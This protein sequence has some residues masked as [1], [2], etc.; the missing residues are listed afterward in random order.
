MR[1]SEEVKA[2]L[3]EP[4][5]TTK[6]LGKGTGL[7]LATCYGIVCQSGGDIRVYS[8]PNAGTTFKIYLPR[9][10]AK[11]DA[12]AN[13]EPGDLPGGTETILVVEDDSAVRKLAVIIL[14]E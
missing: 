14:R 10:D 3:F 13:L 8:E 11:P 2:N 5:F 9:T 12:T 1:I 6:G 4:F 7:G